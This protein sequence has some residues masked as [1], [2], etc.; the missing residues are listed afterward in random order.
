MKKFTTGLILGG[1]ATI[2][3]VGYLMQ[4]QRTCRKIVKKGK[5]MAMRAE[6]AIDD[7]MDDLMP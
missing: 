5:N 7:M 4:D 3:G 6:E 1:I 2:A